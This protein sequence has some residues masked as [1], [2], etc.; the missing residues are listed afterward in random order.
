[1]HEDGNAGGEVTP[2]RT[3]RDHEQL[4]AL[5]DDAEAS[6]SAGDAR[7][8]EEDLKRV[9]VKAAAMWGGVGLPVLPG[10]VR[11]L[12]SLPAQAQ[13]LVARA[14]GS[15]DTTALLD[16]LASLRAIFEKEAAR[17]APETSG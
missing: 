2:G 14:D 3:S 9:G 4:L 15:A 5:L 7:G 1:M 10:P 12:I 13:D 16:R 17:E 6:L 11:D 8:A